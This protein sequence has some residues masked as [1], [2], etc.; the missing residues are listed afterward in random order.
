MERTLLSLRFDVDVDV[1]FDSDLDLSPT[2]HP[3]E[4]ES[5]AKRDTPDEA[6]Q[7]ASI[8]PTDAP[9]WPERRLTVPATRSKKATTL[10]AAFVIS[11]QIRGKCSSVSHHQGR[12]ARD[13]A[14]R[15]QAVHRARRVHDPV[16]RR[17]A[18]RR[19]RHDLRH[20]D[21]RP[22]AGRL[23]HAALHRG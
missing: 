8:F 13:R 22:E 18:V 2:C 20:A 23:P 11:L 16:R 15:R 6:M 12:R 19:A 4:A 5:L 7:L 3:E 14:H 10:V 1:A 21:D 17:R 9:S